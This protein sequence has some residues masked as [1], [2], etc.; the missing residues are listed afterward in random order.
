M[1]PSSTPAPTPR[2]LSCQAC[3]LR[4]I[5]C[6]RSFPCG[7]CAK[8][9]VS[10]VP[11]T[12][13][14]PR[15]RR[16][17]ERELLERLRTYE[18]LLRRN[19][20]DFE[21]LHG[22]QGGSLKEGIIEESHSHV[23]QTSLNTPSPTVST[24]FGSETEAKRTWYAT[25]PGQEVQLDD[26]ESGS[27]LLDDTVRKRA[28]RDAWGSLFDNDEHLMF[29]SSPGPDDRTAL[30][31]PLAQILRLWQVYLDNINP[32][33]K[34]THAPSLQPRIIEAAAD[35]S[36]VDPRLEA[37]MFAIYCTAAC[38]LTDDEGL[39]ILGVPRKDALRRFQ[40]GCQRALVKC[41]FLQT[42]DRNCLT[43]FFL[44][45][46]SL[47]PVTDPRSLSPMIG[48]AVRIARRM[49]IHKE[50]ALARSDVFEAEMRRRLWWSLVFF[51][52]RIGQLAFSD[53]GILGPL[54]DC[55][56]PLNV[57]DAELRPGMSSPPVPHGRGT[58]AA[59]AVTRAEMGDWIRNAPLHLAFTEP[60]LRSAAR[61]LPADGAPSAL[62]SRIEHDYLRHLDQGD[63][64]HFMATWVARGQLAKCHIIQQRTDSA[65]ARTDAERDASLKYACRVLECDTKLLTS[66]L[67]KGFN[68]FLWLHFP[69]PAYLDIVEDL[70]RRPLGPLAAFAWDTMEENHEA[71]FRPTGGAPDHPIKG[72]FGK[73]ILGAWETLQRAGRETGTSVQVPAVVIRVQQWR[74]AK[75]D[76]MQTDGEE[77]QATTS[78]TLPFDL[79]GASG[80]IGFSEGMGY[81]EFSWIGGPQYAM[82]DMM[83]AGGQYGSLD[84]WGVWTD[85][86]PMKNR[87]I[88]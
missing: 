56:V 14:R 26:S 64:T 55:R 79:S 13:S 5:K 86:L 49:G 70:K 10:C 77:A 43:A 75:Q 18:D 2:I 24:N 50:S 39:A 19:N 72:M 65:A 51:D 31:P 41:R 83:G 12:Q 42:D 87:P 36:S 32:L 45:L 60:A 7:N 71:R 53:S 54:W 88:G 46:C 6:D 47:R 68:W 59:F 15:K 25:S 74:A 29:G 62:E 1:T 4:K 80:N 84:H 3:Q 17:P 63:P 20:V 33:L 30:H 35:L 40:K 11:A 58:D 48:I 69:F 21:P 22:G 78:S 73:L 76:E 28:V 61:R 57:G 82:G 85:Q 23:G 27:D 44:Y 9:H 66:P 8:H 37:L 16:F 67:T 81:D 52:T 34:V 38:T